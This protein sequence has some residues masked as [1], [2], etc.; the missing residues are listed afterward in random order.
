MTAPESAP[1]SFSTRSPTASDTPTES[2]HRPAGRTVSSCPL[3]GVHRWALILTSGLPSSPLL[4]TREL[5]SAYG[6]PALP[7]DCEA[8][9]PRV[10]GLSVSVAPAT[11]SVTE[12]TGGVSGRIAD[13]VRA[14]VRGTRLGAQQRVPPRVRRD[15]GPVGRA[16]SAH[17][18]AVPALAPTR[19]A[20]PTATGLARAARHV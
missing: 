6:Q 8:D 13:A 3:G 12:H 2:H 16:R 19:S 17:R 18:Q 5:R 1:S 7:P 9:F 11:V 14:R 20:P 15:S 10:R 4:T